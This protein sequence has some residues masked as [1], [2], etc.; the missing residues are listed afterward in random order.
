MK[1]SLNWVR[2]Y[3]ELPCV[4][5]REILQKLT[6]STCEVEEVVSVGNRLN[7]VAVATVSG[8]EKHPRADKLQ[9]ARCL[10]GGENVQVVTG[11]D[12]FKIGDKLAYVFPGFA[13][14]NGEKIESVS[15]RGVESEGM[16]CSEKELGFSDDHEGLMVLPEEADP[17][18]NLDRLFPDQVDLVLD[19][20]NKSITHRPDLWGH[21]GFARELAALYGLP[22]KPPAK[23]PSTLSGK[24]EAF[25]TTRLESPDP[26]YRFSAISIGN[27]AVRPS[28]ARIRHRLHR[29][30]V[31]AINNLVDATNYVMMDIGQPMHAFDADRIRG[32]RLTVEFARPGERLLTL[33][34]DELELTPECLVFKDGQAPVSLAGVIGGMNSGICE[35]SSRLYLEAA[36]WDPAMIRKTSLRHGI[37]TDA[38]QHYEKS[39]DPQMTTDALSLAVELLRQ[40]CPGLTIRGPLKDVDQN[41][42]PPLSIGLRQAKIDAVIGKPVAPEFIK[43]KLSAIGF[44]VS[45]SEDGYLIGV[46]SWRRTKDVSIPEDVIEEIGRLYD[47]NRIEAKAPRFPL[48]RPSPNA[49]RVFERNA[50]Q[51]LAACGF[52]EIFTYPLTA[53]EKEEAL[54]I[55]STKRMMLKNPV[56]RLQNSLRT[57]LVPFFFEAVVQN[58]RIVEDFGLF[59]IGKTYFKRG[60]GSVERTRLCLVLSTGAEESLEERFQRLK[61]VLLV[62]FARLK[63]PEPDF[64]PVGS[65]PPPYVH[66]FC[67]AE[68]RLDGRFLGYVF[69]PEKKTAES[70]DVKSEPFLADLDFDAMQALPSKDFSVRAT[71]KFPPMLFDF[72]LLVDQRTR[73]DSIE[74]EVKRFDPLIREVSFVDLYSPPEHPG[75]KSLTL[76]IL[77]RSDEKTLGHEEVQSRRNG[78]IEHLAQRGRLL[79][80]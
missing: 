56:N 79:R 27:L 32:S 26:I 70:L 64:V 15:L 69:A 21:Y 31:R 72:S 66:P 5:P 80:I 23:D 61:R 48:E 36:N 51:V 41:R 35:T 75:K 44:S 78:L 16:L 38:S 39:L 46:P 8:L 49:R 11:A 60:E 19:I 54:G 53:P 28:P 37:R 77:F 34:G 76:R 6:L 17:S 47:Y 65:S 25:V 1:I 33:Y 43:E 55:V 74:R 18:Q 63:L 29:V 7:E 42:Y 13:F 12:N 2:D 30:G 45:E 73:F 59:E 71:S 24:G 10:A 52:N 22:L 50:K 40:T 62:L 14:E 3:V 4:S 67:S 20:D 68:L 57:S 58:R 9:I